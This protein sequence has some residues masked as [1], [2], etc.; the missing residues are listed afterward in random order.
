MPHPAALIP[1]SVK[2]SPHWLDSQ[3]VMQQLHISPRTLQRWRNEGKLSF[4]KV[5]GKIW[6]LESDIH[7][8]LMEGR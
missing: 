6:Y 7:Q 1:K 5:R 2:P 4:S 8:L 3:D